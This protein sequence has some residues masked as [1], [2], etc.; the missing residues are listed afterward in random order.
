[1]PAQFSPQIEA[2]Q[3][4]LCIHCGESAGFLRRRHKECRQR[5]ATGVE[6]I[7]TFFAQA[8]EGDVDAERFGELLQRYA[9]AHGVT[10]DELKRLI[11]S[12]LTTALKKVLE[13]HVISADENQRF[14]LLRD[15]F[16]VLHSDL[17]ALAVR[18]AKANILREI[19]DGEVPELAEYEGSPLPNLARGEVLVWAFKNAIQYMIKARTQYVGS[20]QGVSVRLMK[21]VYYRV[22][23]S[24]GERIRTNYLSEE[25]RGAF[26]VTS[27]NVIFISTARSVKLPLKKVVSVQLFDEAFRS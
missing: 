24:K 2:R 9:R 10:D 19:D 7:P 20:S 26:F 23:A 11:V 17:G 15:T 13:D 14:E 25:G 5:H 6:R 16:G 21:G 1:M 4:S 22:G 12:G 18:Y 3:M 8:M 27:H